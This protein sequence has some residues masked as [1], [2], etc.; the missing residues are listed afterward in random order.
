MTQH[1]PGSG[2]IFDVYKYIYI[3]TANHSPGRD[4]RSFG[5]HWK[6]LAGGAARDGDNISFYLGFGILKLPLMLNRKYSFS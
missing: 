6:T 1:C 5:H 3:I 4:K 2:A